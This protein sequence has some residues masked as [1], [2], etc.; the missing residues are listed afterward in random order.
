MPQGRYP[1]ANGRRRAALRH[2]HG[3]L[4]PPPLMP[5]ESYSLS[6]PEILRLHFLHDL[7]QLALSARDASSFDKELAVSVERQQRTQPS[8]RWPCAR[9]TKFN[10][11]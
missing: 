2:R 1:R 6:Y 9:G 5:K 4:P 10:S 8:L 7:S 3:I 11:F